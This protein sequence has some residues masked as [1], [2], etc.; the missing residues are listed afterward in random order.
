MEPKNNKVKTLFYKKSHRAFD[1]FFCLV[2]F[3]QIFII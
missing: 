3:V 2:R 1:D